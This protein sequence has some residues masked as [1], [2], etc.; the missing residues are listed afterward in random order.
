M[1]KRLTKF[2]ESVILP[3]VKKKTLQVVL[4]EDREN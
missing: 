4:Y 3:P 2:T 1:E